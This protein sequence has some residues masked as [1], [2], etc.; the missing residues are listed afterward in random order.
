MI[1]ASFLSMPTPRE[2]IYWKLKRRKGAIEG[3]TG[4]EALIGV[5][6]LPTV[7]PLYA[8]L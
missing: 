4:L 1:P 2:I 3:G 6:T 7:V 5:T 8:D